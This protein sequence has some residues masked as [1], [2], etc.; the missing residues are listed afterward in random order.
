MLKMFKTTRMKALIASAAETPAAQLDL[1]S[2]DRISNDGN[3]G[4]RAVK[5]QCNIN[6]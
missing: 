4:V 6:A 2:S 3:D 1:E 5:M